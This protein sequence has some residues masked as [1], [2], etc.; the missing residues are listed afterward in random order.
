MNRKTK[1][2][3]FKYKENTKD[4]KMLHFDIIHRVILI[5]MYV[6]FNRDFFQMIIIYIDHHFLFI[7][8]VKYIFLAQT[9][10]LRHA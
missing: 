7:I 8:C 5:H 9:C 2:T 3:I 10:N 4:T 6:H 1:Y